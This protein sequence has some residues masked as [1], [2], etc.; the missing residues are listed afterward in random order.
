MLFPFG[1]KPLRL[2]QNAARFCENTWDIMLS[3]LAPKEEKSGQHRKGSHV[4]EATWTL[5]LSK[6]QKP[7]E[8]YHEQAS[9][10]SGKV[11]MN[12]AASSKQVRRKTCLTEI[13]QKQVPFTMTE[14]T[15]R[16]ATQTVVATT[17]GA[18]HHFKHS[19]ARANRRAIR[20]A[21]RWYWNSRT[22]NGQVFGNV[23]HIQKCRHQSRW[24]WSLHETVWR[25]TW[26][27]ETTST[28]SNQ[29]LLWSWSF[30]HHPSL[31]ILSK[32][33]LKSHLY[34]RHSAIWKKAMLQRL[35]RSSDSSSPRSRS[36]PPPPPQKK[37]RV[38]AE[39]TKTLGNSI[40]RNKWD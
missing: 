7:F 38:I 35:C 22:F 17:Q 23:P 25:R 27:Y 36:C 2:C 20:H 19:R 9:S 11:V 15:A 14:P 13:R 8:L 31:A 21:S 6:A 24:C 3:R 40:Y 5:V 34:L 18:F 1:W 10:L 12:A 37:R 32:V 30:A 16:V 28:V 33:G 39:S 29:Q 26:V 4:F